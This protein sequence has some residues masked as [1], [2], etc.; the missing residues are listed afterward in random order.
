MNIK[1]KSAAGQP[2]DCSYMYTT[3]ASTNFKHGQNAKVSFCYRF[4]CRFE[5]NIYV[6]L[7]ECGPAHRRANKTFERKQSKETYK[8]CGL[9]F[10]QRQQM[11]DVFFFGLLHRANELYL[12]CTVTHL[13]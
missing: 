2:L 4:F 5:G 9:I 1:F 6:N 11:H 3:N 7:V 10:M 13:V 8:T 12:N